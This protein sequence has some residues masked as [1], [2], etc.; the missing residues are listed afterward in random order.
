MESKYT[1]VEG[2]AGT[3]PAARTLTGTYSTVGTKIIGAGT[4][5]ANE[6]FPNDYLYSP[7]SGAHEVRRISHVLDNRT[8]YLEEAFSADVAAGTD[9]KIVRSRHRKVI[10]E[11]IGSANGEID[12][13]VIEA[14]QKI[15][16]ESDYAV[17]PLAYDATTANVTL[18][19]TTD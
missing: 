7:A 16:L 8:A 2:T 12:N 11:N 6:L 18:A 17:K 13:Q 3:L 4:D 15:T 5:F 10:I 9:V 14:G 1:V 19:I